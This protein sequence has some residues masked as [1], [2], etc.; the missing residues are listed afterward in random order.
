MTPSQVERATPPP[1]ERVIAR[2]PAA[3]PSPARKVLK[4][5]S[6]RQPHRPTHSL[7]V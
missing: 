7:K 5:T 2:T 4:L 3:P 1:A 6:C